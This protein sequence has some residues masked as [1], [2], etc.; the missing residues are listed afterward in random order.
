MRYAMM[1]RNLGEVIVNVLW[2]FGL[3]SS[4]AIVAQLWLWDYVVE[5]NKLADDEP[6]L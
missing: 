5:K 1:A 3:G 2:S 4:G 6:Y